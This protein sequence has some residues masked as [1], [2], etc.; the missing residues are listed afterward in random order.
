MRR[1]RKAHYLAISLIA[2]FC[3]AIG[4][5]TLWHVRAPDL[6]ARVSWDN[7]TQRLVTVIALLAAVTAFA[8]RALPV[9]SGPSTGCPVGI[10]GRVLIV[11]MLLSACCA[12]AYFVEGPTKPLD[13]ATK[14]SGERNEATIADIH[15]EMTHLEARSNTLI[16][17]RTSLP[18]VLQSDIIQLL[19]RLGGIAITELELLSGEHA[20][21]F[22]EHRYRKLAGVAERLRMVAHQIYMYL[23]ELDE[24]A[25]AFTRADR[26]CHT[27]PSLPCDGDAPA[28]T[29]HC[30]CAH[31]YGQIELFRCVQ[32]TAVNQAQRLMPAR[33]R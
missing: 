3:I 29:M 15:S 30:R 32:T 22:I 21:P 28:L 9:P 26:P 4:M 31:L 8:A 27:S 2:L 12:W 20:L 11:I 25:C 18:E 24:T 14:R 16:A 10:N 5:L 13:E 1:S 33:K 6:G 19:A 7:A 17:N 23:Q